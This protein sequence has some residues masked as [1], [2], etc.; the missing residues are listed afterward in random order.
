MRQSPR[1]QRLWQALADPTRRRIVERLAAG[2]QTVMELAGRFDISQPAVTKH[3]NVLEAAGVIRRMRQGRQ[4]R[5]TLRAESL[6][7]S[8]EW[9][10]QVRSLWNARLDAFEGLLAER[11]RRDAGK[12]RAR[13]R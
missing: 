11:T 2:D 7:T 9:L 4:R 6:Q 13:G 10:E 3:L 8:L 12:P 5:C 1:E